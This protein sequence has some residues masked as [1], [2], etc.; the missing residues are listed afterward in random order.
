[1][2]FNCP[3]CYQNLEA[4][5]SVGQQVQC[6]SCGQNF[7]VPAV[8]PAVPVYPVMQPQPGGNYMPP[9]EKSGG[10]GGCLL[11]L[12]I[13]AGSFGLAAWHFNESPQQL[14]V[15]LAKF[16]QTMA[17]P[18]STPSPTP[19]PTPEATPTPV[20]TPAITL[21]PT[22]TPLPTATPTPED[23]MTWLLEHKD[24]WPKEVV[25]KE[26]VNFPAV[27]NGKVIGTTQVPAG[28]K[29]VVVNLEP[30]WVNGSY[31]G[32]RQRIAVDIT[33]LRQRA[34]SAL[35]KA[36]ADSKAAANPEASPEANPFE[37]T[38]APTP[39]Q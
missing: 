8:V 28:G 6:P 20:P 21:T 19:A 16:V 26:A 24:Y 17:Q 7:E 39:A 29:I 32:G 34:K 4:N 22:P 15:R 14:F 3:H 37:F 12:V 33:D 38:P 11:F 23:P 36:I 30:G 35:Q 13:L 5:V 1:M 10:N 25:L 27:F 2:K 9:Q 31:S 18:A